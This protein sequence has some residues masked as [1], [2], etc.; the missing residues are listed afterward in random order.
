MLLGHKNRE[1]IKFPVKKQK[2][3]FLQEDKVHLYLMPLYLKRTT[4]KGNEILKEKTILQKNKSQ[5]AEYS[6]FFPENILFTQHILF[7]LLKDTII[8]LLLN[9]KRT[10]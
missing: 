10:H 6:T 1:N 5:T 3:N 4:T 7:L 9:Y 8:L 2:V